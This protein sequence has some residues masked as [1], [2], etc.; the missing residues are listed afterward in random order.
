MMEEYYSKHFTLEKIR[1]G[2]YAAISKPGGGSVGNAGFIDLGD[3]TIVF[4]TF[5]T[6]QAAEDLK[7]VAEKITKRC[8]TWVVNS[9]WHGDHI[10]GNQAFKESIIISSQM[11]YEKMREI[12]PSRISKQKSDINGLTTYI[13]SLKDQLSESYESK[14]EE[15]IS[16]L[17]EIEAS[18]PNLELTLPHQTF[19]DEITFYGSKRSAKLYT[20]GGGHSYCDAILY[21]P[22]EK[23]I[24]MGDLLFVNT[25]PTIFE[26]SDPTKWVQILERLKE[27]DI[28]VAVPGHGPV[29]TKRTLSEIIDYIT[30]ITEIARTTK[31]DTPLPEKYQ[32]WHSSEIYNQNLIGMRQ[33]FN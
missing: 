18:L 6:Q 32:T 23:V 13:Q 15:Q 30:D 14:L 33:R 11:T 2:I 5:N 4:D 9:H 29:G 3:Q 22:E 16:F 31:G 21:I 10:R 7:T 20:F 8:V 19:K 24:F 12:H 17:S 25:H 26:D 28:D 1:E 27:L